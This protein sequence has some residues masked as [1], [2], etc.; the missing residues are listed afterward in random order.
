MSPNA[1]KIDCR[2]RLARPEDLPKLEALRLAIG[3]PNTLLYPQGSFIRGAIARLRDCLAKADEL[4]DWRL[5]VLTEGD[6]EPQAYLLFVVDHEH[7]VTHQLQTVILD[8]AVPAFSH[9]EALVGRARKVATAFENEYLVADIPA[10]DKRLQL[11]F[12]RCG[13]RAEQQR[14]VK[15]LEPHPLPPTATYRVRPARAADLAF[16][17]EV[18]S[19]NARFYL[20]P[21]RDVDPE[22]VKL[23]YQMAYLSLDFESEQEGCHYLILEEVSSGIPAGYIFLRPGAVTGAGPTLYIYDVAVAPQ[24]ANRGLSR[25]L[26]EAAETQAAAS[27]R[28]IYGD[29]SLGVSSMASWHT[30]L[31]CVVDSY[32]YALDCRPQGQEADVKGM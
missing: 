32:L 29:G 15:P 1:P 19:A 14:V 27:G 18:L 16:V 5:L 23:H 17:L 11:W 10:S 20:P 8:Y 6:G 12:Y 13:F 25:Y 7:G 4:P 9:L 3:Y 2:I 22:T 21:G 28:L 31:G 24:F 30:Q 26:R